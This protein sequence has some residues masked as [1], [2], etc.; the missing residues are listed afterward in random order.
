MGTENRAH[1]D[2]A[3][4]NDI[5]I[6]VFVLTNLSSVEYILSLVLNSAFLLLCT[7]FCY[8][9]LVLLRIP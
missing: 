6:P 3:K 5:G 7:G 1:L 8:L 4:L 2:S 9:V